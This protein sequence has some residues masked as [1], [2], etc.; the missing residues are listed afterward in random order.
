[1]AIGIW[2]YVKQRVEIK[3][4]QSACCDTGMQIEHHCGIIRQEEKMGEEVYLDHYQCRRFE[5]HY[6]NESS[7]SIAASDLLESKSYD[8]HHHNILE[9]L[10]YT[11]ITLEREQSGRPGWFR[12]KQWNT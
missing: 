7:F 9:P 10:G 4:N 6:F 1:M 12:I 8:S 3:K 11:M 5:V 2:L